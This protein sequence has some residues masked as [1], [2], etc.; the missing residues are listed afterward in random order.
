MFWSWEFF[1]PIPIIDHPED[2]PYFWGTE[3]EVNQGEE[4]VEEEEGEEEDE[5]SVRLS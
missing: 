3:G 1:L 5:E 2:S 4:I